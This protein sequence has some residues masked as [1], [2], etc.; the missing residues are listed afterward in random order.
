MSRN[1]SLPFHLYVNVDNKYLGP[2][3]PNGVTQAIWHAVYC[4]EYQ[5][6]MAHIL[7]ESGAHWSGLP[8]QAISTTKDFSWEREQLMP[9]AAMGDCIE[10][11]YA[12]YLE[13]LECNVFKPIQ[14][15]GR[16]TGII[17]DWTDG[18]SRY[19]S[20]HKPLNVIHLENGQFAF[21]PNN[22]IIYNDKHFTNE[23]AKE[24]LK[25]YRRGETVYW[26]K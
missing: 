10:S 16:H 1:N 2:Q 12:K 7:L 5:T 19:P 6:L 9:W 23:A 25:Y 26:E 18:F 24:N 20:E 21:L 14:S 15:K 22:F 11:F 8:I 17:I 4:R 13:G 3:M